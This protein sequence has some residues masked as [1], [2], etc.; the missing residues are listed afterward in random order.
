[1]S[2]YQFI[3][4]ISVRESGLEF[5]TVKNILQPGGS[6]R[7]MLRW[8]KHRVLVPVT[9]GFEQHLADVNSCGF[10]AL[11][12]QNFLV[13]NHLSMETDCCGGAKERNTRPDGGR[14]VV[15]GTPA[16]NELFAPRTPSGRTPEITNQASLSFPGAK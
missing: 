13:A 1:M 12:L 5:V 4:T 9:S 11:R 10:I 6:G 15:G 8:I 2:L 14:G 7:T 16:S 3:R